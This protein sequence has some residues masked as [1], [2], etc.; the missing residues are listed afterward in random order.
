MNILFIPHAST[1]KVRVRSHEL[2]MA[3][4]RQ[5]PEDMIYYL[6]WDE[7]SGSYS[8]RNLLRQIMGLLIAIRIFS[9]PRPNFVMVKIPFLYRPFRLA[10]I[11]NRWVISRIITRFDINSIVN[12]SLC[13]VPV[14]R[15]RPVQAYLYD[16]V[17]DHFAPPVKNW[18][19]GRIFA[20]REIAKAARVSACSRHL[21]ER[22]RQLCSCSAEYIPNGVHGDAFAT[23][24]VADVDLLRKK[25]GIAPDSIVV[26]IIGNLSDLAGSPDWTGLRFLARTIEHLV[27]QHPEFHLVVVGGGSAVDDI[28]KTYADRR[29]LTCVGWVNPDAVTAYFSMLNIG[30]I[31]FEPS[32]YSNHALPI[33]A[34]EYGMAA[35]WVVSTPL[36]ELVRS[37]FPNFLYAERQETKWENA[38]IEASQKK[39]DPRWKE[40]FREYDWRHAAVAMRKLLDGQS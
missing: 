32:P 20:G 29:W 14:P 36:A 28:R 22:L 23:V 2:A 40:L 39:F 35:K 33:K 19:A 38:L 1:D 12:A 37:G 31:P 18:R 26:G 9:R 3:M 30:V 27:N 34:I 11:F 8:L 5:C 4:A 13:Y 7:I 24:N 25:T 6:C 17:D 16:V 15:G 21:S 10:W